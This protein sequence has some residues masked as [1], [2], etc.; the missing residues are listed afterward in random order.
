MLAARRPHQPLHPQV[1]LGRA[2]QGHLQ[3][4]VVGRLH[5]RAGLARNPVRALR[6]WGNPDWVPGSGST[7]PLGGTA[8]QNA[9]ADPPAGARRP[10][11]ARRRLLEGA[12]TTSS[13]EPTPSPLPI[14][15]WQIWNE[16]NLKKFF[17][18]YPRPASTR[19]C[20]RSPATRSA[21]RTR[22][23]R[24]CWPG[25]RATGTSTA[26]DFLKKLYAV[27]SIKTFFDAAAL[28]PYAPNLSQFRQE[29]QQV[30]NVIKGHGDAATPLWISEL[31]WGSAPP[32]SFGINKGPAGQAQ[33][34]TRAFK[35]VL[36]NRTAWNVQRLFWYH[37]R[38]P[39]A[40]PRASCS[41][42]GSAGLLNFN[43]TPK[44]AYAAFKLHDR[45]DQADGD[46]HRRGRRTG[47]T[48][49]D[50]TPTFKFTSSE[51]G[52]TFLCS[53]GG[54]P[55]GLRL[56]RT[57]CA[58]LSDGTHTFY[59]RAIDA[60]GNDEPAGRALLH[61]RHPAPGD[62][63]DHVHQPGVA[64]QRQRPEVIG[65]AAA[66]HDD[67]DLQDGGLHRHPG[68]QGVGGAVQV[69]RDHR[70]R[71]PTTR[72]PRCAPRR[73]TRPATRPAARAGFQLRR[74]LDSA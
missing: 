23:P 72:R 12:R 21:A 63:E 5:R 9:V 20:F 10:L 54:S 4:E 3:M 42:C 26:W 14:Q 65:T 36:A 45:H 40:D 53:I 69:A 28:H 13:S 62:P 29:I 7:P 47:R 61:G 70:R 30:R 11:R 37:W 58:H 2:H 33:M 8:T 17:A 32:D 31:A 22:A 50:P 24:S 43:R 25:C 16:P 73:P 74:G 44:P 19:G 46:D 57:R 51:P 56:A 64:G 38:D 41:F 59:V 66:G 67:Q 34:L 35:L 60:A 52:S 18:P 6:C 71:C 27:R 48:I 39:E 55:Q 68:G 49:N 15:S 1:G